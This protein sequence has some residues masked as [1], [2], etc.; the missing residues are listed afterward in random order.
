[1]GE[2]NRASVPFNFAMNFLLRL[3]GTICAAISYP[4][5]FRM[6]GEA[7]MGKAAF[8]ASV[9]S[10][11][12]LLAGMGVSAYGVRECARVRDDPATLRQTARELLC[13]QL[14]MTLTSMVLLLIAV[15]AVPRLWENRLL[16]LI[17]GGQLLFHALDTEWLFAAEERY[18]FLTVRSFVTKL[19]AV[20]LIL[21]FVRR[22][23]DYRLYALITASAAVLGYLWNFMGAGKRLR[24]QG[25][26]LR[27]LRHLRA[28]AVFCLQSAAVTVYTGLD[29]VLLGFLKDDAMVGVY[30]AA[31]KIRSVLVMFIASLSAVLLPRFSYYLSTRQEER[32]RRGLR[33]SSSFVL[34]IT[35]PLMAYF[36]L[37]GESCL[38]VLYDGVSGDTL[39]CLRILI[40]TVFLVG[41]SNTT[42]IQLLTPMNMERTV[43][44]ST[45]VGAAV[46]LIA[47]LLLIPGLGAVGAALGTLIAETA[48]LAVQLFAVRKLGI[49]LME[50]KSALRILLVA[51]AA[52]AE[53]A[54]LRYAPLPAPGKVLLGAV[55]YFGTVWSVLLA[56][57][58]PAL[59]DMAAVLR[60]RIR[61]GSNDGADGR[62]GRG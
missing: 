15:A 60:S 34:L 54:L 17:Q 29:S 43:T 38:T 6:I 37:L 56:L 52:C 4:F 46:D 36:L 42:G 51:L 32:F 28:S 48:V 58:D 33:M 49:R 3:S 14:T 62:D 20:A 10:F 1:M 59:T 12:L 13:L 22:P 19:A 31:A 9:G 50:P 26:R 39:R 25:K 5:A 7:G 45:V 16:F 47:D 40:P 61:G 21:L 44:L 11:F 41:C 35:L 27:P 53:L 55:L 18:A 8:A 2:S 30:D 24:G 23:E 57:K